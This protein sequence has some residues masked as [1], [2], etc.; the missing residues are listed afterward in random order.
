M[1]AAEIGFLLHQETFFDLLLAFV[2]MRFVNL[3]LV[4]RWDHFRPGIVPLEAL[5][6]IGINE[7]EFELGYPRELLAGLLDFLRTQTRDLDQDPIFPDRADNRFAAAEIVDAFPDDFH[8]LFEQL[9]RDLLIS[10]HEPDQEGSA[11]LDVEAE[12]DLLFGRI[13]RLQA[14]SG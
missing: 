8:G 14:E 6:A 10:A 9:R 3:D 7:A 1:F 2:G 13:N 12:L 4:F 5:A 11:A